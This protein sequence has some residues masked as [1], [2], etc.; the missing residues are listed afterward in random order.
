MS[1]FWEQDLEVGYYDKL[2]TRSLKRSRGFQPNWHRLTLKYIEPHLTIGKQH[3]DY[4]CGPGTLIGRYSKASSLGVDISSSQIKYAIENYKSDFLSLSEFDFKKYKN[5]FDIVTIVGLFEF[6][7][8]N[9][10]YQLMNKISF[11]MKK[12]SEII[13]TTP[14]FTM[15]FRFLMYSSILLGKKN[16]SNIYKS[17]FKKNSLHEVLKEL[18]DFEI[19]KTDKI[20][21]FGLF[22]TIFSTKLGHRV[23]DLI[24]K[25]T[26]RNFGLLLVSHLIKK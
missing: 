6:L 25:I 11:M 22:L 8:T 1:K 16:Y 14:N 5:R 4:A 3:L 9:E 21:N 24:Y 17:K 26:D 7:D 20:L 10:I 23:E 2:L 19:I 12:N 13:I 18:D 15:L